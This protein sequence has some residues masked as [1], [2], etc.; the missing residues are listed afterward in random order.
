MKKAE[1]EEKEAKQTEGGIR[2]GGVRS[3]KGEGEVIL[4]QNGNKPGLRHSKRLCQQTE[5][6]RPHR[7]WDRNH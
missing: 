2:I 3:S 7:T 6:K 5:K 4:S 1:S